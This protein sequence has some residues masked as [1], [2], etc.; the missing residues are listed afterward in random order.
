[1]KDG[2]ALEVNVDLSRK[3]QSDINHV[4]IRRKINPEIQVVVEV[5]NTLRDLAPGGQRKPSI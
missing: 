4:A 2:R 1:M 3:S 5:D